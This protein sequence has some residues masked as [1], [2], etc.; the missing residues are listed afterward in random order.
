MCGTTSIPSSGREQIE[1]GSEVM[2]RCPTSGDW[3]EGVVSS[4]GIDEL[5]V[6]YFHY[7]R[8]MQLRLPTCSPDIEL[9]RADGAG[10]NSRSSSPASTLSACKPTRPNAEEDHI[11][12]ARHIPQRSFDDAVPKLADEFAYSGKTVVFCM[13]EDYCD[14][15]DD[16]EVD[17]AYDPGVEFIRYLICHCPGATCEVNILQGGFT[18]WRQH[19]SRDSTCFIARHP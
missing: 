13:D 17:D 16:E 12:G 15:E 8:A 1:V 2:V 19:V 3:K 7:T 9:K 18:A 5:K 6:V 4:V 14:N 10:S 11:F